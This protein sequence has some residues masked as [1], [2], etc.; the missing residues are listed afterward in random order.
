MSQA[1]SGR[2]LAD[3]S[4]NKGTGAEFLCMM[5]VAQNR[6]SCNA[7]GEKGGTYERRKPSIAR[8]HFYRKAEADNGRRPA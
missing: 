5:G 1:V 2:S 8:F 4:K 6:N 3:F 7:T